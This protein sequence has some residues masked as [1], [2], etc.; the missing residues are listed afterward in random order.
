[1]ASFFIMTEG[2]V[3]IGVWEKG[4]LG[5]FRS[6]YSGSA[7]S[8]HPRGYYAVLCMKLD[9]YVGCDLDFGEFLLFCVPKD[10]SPEIRRFDSIGYARATSMPRNMNRCCDPVL[11]VLRSLPVRCS[12]CLPQDTALKNLF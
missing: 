1:M 11:V 3:K 5:L 9:L 12:N 8:G 6:P 7:F 2:G 10:R 4:L